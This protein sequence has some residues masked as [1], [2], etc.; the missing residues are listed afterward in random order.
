MCAC[1]RVTL[2]RQCMYWP[3][4]RTYLP[5]TLEVSLLPLWWIGSI[6]A[7]QARGP[8]VFDSAS[9]RSQPLLHNVYMSVC[10]GGGVN[11]VKPLISIIGM[12]IPLIWKSVENLKFLSFTNY[13]I[14]LKPLPDDFVKATCVSHTFHLPSLIDVVSEHLRQETLKFLA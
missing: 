3:C 10:V 1:S 12:G 2:S 14:S 9:R 11:N 8:R 4:Q 13:V 6:H 7:W 5:R